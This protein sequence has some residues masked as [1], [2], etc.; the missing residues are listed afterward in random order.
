VAGIMARAGLTHGG[1]YAHFASK[2]ALVAEACAA[3]VCDAGAKFVEIAR[4]TPA[5]DRARAIADAYLTRERRDEGG[6]TI[7]TLGGELG[8]QPPAVREAFTRAFAESI[9]TLAPALPGDDAEARTDHALALLTSMIG[10]MMVSRAV[11]DPALRDRILDAARR[12]VPRVVDEPRDGG[13][14]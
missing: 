10:A 3:A 9:E 14:A 8:R 7:A 2:D 13:D 6:C 5:E 12:T 4:A 11:S 1:F